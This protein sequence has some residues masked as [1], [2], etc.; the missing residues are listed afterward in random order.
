MKERKIIMKSTPKMQAKMALK[1]IPKKAR[2]F[3]DAHYHLDDDGRPEKFVG[4]ACKCCNTW[5]SYGHKIRCPVKKLF[6]IGKLEDWAAFCNSI[7]LAQ[8]IWPDPDYYW[9]G[10]AEFCYDSLTRKEDEMPEISD[11]LKQ[12]LVK[13]FMHQL[14]TMTNIVNRHLISNPPKT[15]YITLQVV[16]F[17]VVDSA[18]YD[19]SQGR[20]TELIVKIAKPETVS[21]FVRDCPA[22]STVYCGEYDRVIIP[23]ENTGHLTDDQAR[24]P[25]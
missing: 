17:G 9:P 12:E 21:M 1:L 22:S 24:V 7:G 2:R 6:S 25:A 20:F 11:E 5:L 16:L 23:L 13:E 15:L 3:Y 19:V 4:L 14:S 10:D 8:K 18:K